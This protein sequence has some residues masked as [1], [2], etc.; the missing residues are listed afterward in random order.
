MKKTLFILLSVLCGSLSLSSV[1]AIDFKNDFLAP[2]LVWEES[3]Y[4]FGAV[5]AGEFSGIIDPQRPLTE[6]LK[7][8]FYPPVFGDEATQWWE[9]WRLIRTV[10]VG[11]LVVMFIRAGGMFVRN[12]NNPD[13]IQKSMMNM[14]YILYGVVLFFGVTWILGT[15]LD[16]WDFDGLLWSDAEDGI[17]NK[18][19]NW[20]VLQAIWFL[21]A[22]AFFMAIVFVARYGYKMAIAS[23][24]EERIK[25]AKTGLLN[26]IIALV[27]I[28][29]VD[30]VYFVAQAWNIKETWVELIVS[31]TQFFSFVF[32]GIIFLSFLYVWFM[33]LTSAGS[34]ER[35][36]SAWKFLKNLIIVMLVV[37]LFLLIV[38]Q[39][40]ADIW[41]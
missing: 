33:Y 28:K 35:I 24:S 2:L 12:A 23:D 11:I 18:L 9:I 27:L 30:Y 26:V 13:E 22:L 31:T 8:I 1:F 3:V 20:I 25:S 15:L 21:K 6:N 37:F 7:N 40:F 19:E 41:A 29:V 14:L 39:I 32:G 36:S 17:V 16:I 4:D 34:E 38:Y 10:W 5:D